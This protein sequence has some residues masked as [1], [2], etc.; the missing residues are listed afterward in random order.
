LVDFDPDCGP[1]IV[2]G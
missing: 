2:L 1:V